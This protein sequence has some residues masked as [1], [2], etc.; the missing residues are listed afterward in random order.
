MTIASFDSVYT[1]VGYMKIVNILRKVIDTA[2]VWVKSQQ[3]YW[4]FDVFRI[5]FHH[6]FFLVSLNKG[7]RY[8]YSTDRG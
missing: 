3:L 2:S 6:Y 8:I 4:V 1:I 5:N 7:V